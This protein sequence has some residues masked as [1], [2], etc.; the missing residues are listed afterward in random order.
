MSFAPTYTP[1][2]VIIPEK[3][4]LLIKRLDEQVATMKKID[5]K[6]SRDYYSALE[7]VSTKLKVMID[8]WDRIYFNIRLPAD[9]DYR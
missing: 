5:P 8:S 3:I 9:Y 7:E 2:T 4:I 6:G 1:T